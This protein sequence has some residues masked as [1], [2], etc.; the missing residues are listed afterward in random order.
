MCVR[1]W[2][3][4]RGINETR[5]WLYPTIVQPR[6]Q[7]SFLCFGRPVKDEDRREWRL[8]ESIWLKK[9]SRPARIVNRFLTDRFL[10]LQ[11]YLRISSDNSCPLTPGFLQCP[12]SIIWFSFVFITPFL[13]FSSFISWRC[14]LHCRLS[15]SFFSP[16]LLFFLFYVIFSL[17][18]LYIFLHI[19]F[20]IFNYNIYTFIIIV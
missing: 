12:P 16:L 8:C 11:K 3:C 14:S 7:L 15:L 20:F 4:T 18:F 17:Y 5:R 13:F 10:F 6:Q 2:T 19:Y 1:S 9:I